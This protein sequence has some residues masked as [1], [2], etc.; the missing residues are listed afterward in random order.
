MSM[1]WSYRKAPGMGQKD[2]R[3]LQL[4]CQ[5]NK[6]SQMERN[7][8]GFDVYCSPVIEQLSHSC[9]YSFMFDGEFFM[10]EL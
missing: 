7:L 1:Y 3:D 9:G 4:F 8:L 6:L 10:R 2:S 5:G